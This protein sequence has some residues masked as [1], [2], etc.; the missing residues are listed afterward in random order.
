MVRV[1]L[2]KMISGIAYLNTPPLGLLH[3]STKLRVSQSLDENLEQECGFTMQM[4]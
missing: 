1:H 2:I 4:L 3:K